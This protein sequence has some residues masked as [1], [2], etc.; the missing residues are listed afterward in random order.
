MIM[1]EEKKPK[2]PRIG[3]VTPNAEN[4]DGHYEKVA[5]GEHNS[6]SPAQRQQRPYQPRPYGQQGYQ[7]RPYQQRPYQ[8]RP[9][10]QRPAA[11]GENT[12]GQQEQQ[13][14]QPR[15]QDQQ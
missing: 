10:Q 8:Q 2:R 6:Y 13:G 1:E 11:E 14:Y 15:Q 3:G 12:E 5:Y 7:Q 4:S 9:Y